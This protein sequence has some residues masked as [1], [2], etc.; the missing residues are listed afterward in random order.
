MHPPMP[1][2]LS[3]VVC[4]VVCAVA[5]LT[6]SQIAQTDAGPSPSVR[7]GTLLL[8]GGGLDNDAKP[9][10]ERLL[11]LAAAHGEPRIVIATAASGDQDAELT[12]KTEA[13]RAFAPTVSIDAI[14]RETTTEATVAAIDAATALLFT[15]G[16]QQRI[17]A[18]YRPEDRATP[19]WLAM[20][21]L[22]A[23]GGVIA[24]CSA[25]DAMMGEVMLLSGRSARALGIAPAAPS[26]AG[27]PAAALGP[28]V[29]PGM[30]FL[31]WAITDSHFFERDRLG[32]LVAALEATGRRFGIGVG[33]DACVEIDLATGVL[34]GITAAESLLVDVAHLRRDGLARRNV[35][36][37][38]IGQGDSVPLAARRATSP[39]S[40]PARPA[41]PARVVPVVE[42]GQNRQLASWRLFRHA[43]VPGSGVVR[44]PFADWQATAW[45]AAAGEVVC[46]VEPL[47]PVMVFVLAGQSNMEGFG[48][49]AALDEAGNQRPGTLTRLVS[50][51]ATAFR[52][53]H[54]VDDRPVAAAATTS[55]LA[56]NDSFGDPAPGVRKQL[57]VVWSVAGVRG[58]RIVAEGETLTVEAPPRLV[59]VERAR[60]GDLVRGVATDVTMRV[61]A[62]VRGA[63][64]TPRWRVRDDVFV[65][66]L[67][68]SGPLT[69]GFGANPQLFGIELQFGH[70]LGDALDAPV[71]LVKAAWGGRSLH[72]DFRPPS[73]GGEVGA[74]YRLLLD[75]VA[76][77]LVDLPKL[78]PTLAG[79][80]H[81]LAGLV[82]W[83]GWND[84][85]D[86][87]HA[88][89]AYEQNLVHL[90]QDLRRD[91]QAPDL[92][93]V[94]GELTGPWVDPTEPEWIGVRK[95]QAAAAAHA[96]FAGTVAFVKT[97]D[98]VRVEQDSPGG[99]ACHEWNN[100]ETYWLV[101]NACGEAMKGLLGLQAK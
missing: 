56:S 78:S 44:L 16:D 89:P 28:S 10:F 82:W 12:D 24:G 98:F 40:P 71:V 7:A 41:G 52:F 23:R 6:P 37:R 77:A 34:R 18:R 19:E 9:V 79:R 58:E 49:I 35:L 72:V 5:L 76:Q 73:A 68:R 74:H 69:T 88:V 33:E 14:R 31:P 1:R 46:D 55:V 38:L 100:A 45:A 59:V 91:L 17:T 94:I 90:I 39:P 30:H 4:A 67:G 84:G 65:H 13:L 97:R 70:V 101:G 85:C 3:T 21:R 2:S 54:L 87:K 11:A 64:L 27:E 25:G 22:L 62:L 63:A 51:P 43:S 81:R 36:A 92:P 93:V 53:A 57:E 29:G 80:E 42:P 61:Q 99:W 48:Q 20:Q 66:F 50:D 15:G 83:H 75:V 26:A 95:A 86:P 47:P 96:G 8:I 32:R 60:Y